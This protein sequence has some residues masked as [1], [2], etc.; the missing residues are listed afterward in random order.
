MQDC[1]VVMAGNPLQL[2]NEINK[3]LEQ[4]YKL[5][6][7]VAVNNGMYVALVVRDKKWKKYL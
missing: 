5:S 6:G 1:R 2:Q 7:G 4:G 3:M